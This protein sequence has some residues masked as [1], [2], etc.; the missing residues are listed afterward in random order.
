MLILNWFVY[1]LL[2]IQQTATPRGTATPKQ[3]SP[4]TD[5]PHI[6]KP[7]IEK[8]PA[9]KPVPIKAPQS[10]VDT[11]QNVEKV[12]ESITVEAADPS[13]KPVEII[14]PAEIVTTTET[15]ETVTSIEAQENKTD[16]ITSESET[17]SNVDTDTTKLSEPENSEMTGR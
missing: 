17:V 9:A 15:V 10:S 8:V 2:L 12:T 14:A 16:S 13:S 3:P 6:E 5:K 1:F 11:V 7:Q 4:Q